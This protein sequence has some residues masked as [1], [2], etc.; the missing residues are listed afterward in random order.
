MIRLGRLLGGFWFADAPAARLAMLRILIGA[1]ALYLTAEH[2]T[3]WVKIGHTSE[4]L[5]E[6]VGVVVFLAKPLPPRVFQGLLIT[7]LVVNVAFIVGWRYR[8]TGPVFAVLLFGVLS[9]R[10]SWS[11]IYHSANLTVLHVLA[12]GL[13][14]A[15]DALSLDARRRRALAPA[16]QAEPDV[17]G[18][19][20]YGW[21]IKLIC[22]IT[23][24]T[25]LLAGVAKV[26]GPLG[27]SW[28]TAEGLRSQAAADTLR[29][30]VLGDVGSRLLHAVYDQTW[31]FAILA[32]LSLALE[33]GA[34][35]ALFNKRLGR[36][37]AFA[38]FLMH[39]GIYFL[40]GITFRYQLSGVA[41]APFFDVERVLKPFSRSTVHDEQW[42]GP[43][44]GRVLSTDRQPTPAF[45]RP[46]TPV[47]S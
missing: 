29:K 5:F 17:A 16:G 27:W 22:A 9:Y 11:M 45:E 43:S 34:P 28:A 21:P 32:P 18:H 6:P 31:L 3:S 36:A 13:A 1:F 8:L 38:A 4:S 7:C 39:W 47:I 37:W 41:F 2:Y 14:P 24:S 33:L 42:A 46:S 15:A 19:W 23:V 12:L 30:E 10:N 20:R 40:M 44:E 26:A 25:Y 35:L